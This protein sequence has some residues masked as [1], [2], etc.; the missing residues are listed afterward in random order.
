MSVRWIRQLSL[1]EARRIAQAQIEELRELA[2]SEQ[3][4]QYDFR[5]RLGRLEGHLQGITGGIL[6]R[7]G[8]V[9]RR[10]RAIET[11]L[12]EDETR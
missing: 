6:E 12:A 10:L 8:D 9:E 4:I 3:R 7:L 1:E 11:R 2:R 5:Q